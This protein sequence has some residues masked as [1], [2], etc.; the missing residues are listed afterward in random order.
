MKIRILFRVALMLLFAQL[1]VSCGSTV[2]LTGWKNPKE[3]QKIGSIVVWAMFERLAYQEPFEQ[4]ATACFNKKGLKAVESLKF[5][6]PGKKY[7][8]T[9]LEKKF[10]SMGVDGLVVITYKGLERSEDYVPQ[11]TTTYPSYYSNYYSY[12]NW[13]YPV[14][15]YGSNVVTTGGYWTTSSKIKLHA[16]LYTKSDNGLMWSADI[17]V[18]D[19]EYIDEVTNRIASKMYSDWKKE[20]LLK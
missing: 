2:D 18:L 5:L 19:P 16:N 20:G 7:E 1:I 14:Y 9:E 13:G 4:Y 12:Y 8:L 6:S 11:S 17:S 15:G 3:N 10:D